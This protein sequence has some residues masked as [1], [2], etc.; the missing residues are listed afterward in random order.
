MV[1]HA[2]ISGT[3]G[4]RYHGSARTAWSAVTAAWACAC[5]GGSQKPRTIAP[6]TAA[7]ALRNSRRFISLISVLVFIVFLASQRGCAMDGLANTVVGS[8]PA[9]VGHLSIDVGV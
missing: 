8:A 1:S 5:S 6:P 4:S 3:T 7:V 2:L 9:G